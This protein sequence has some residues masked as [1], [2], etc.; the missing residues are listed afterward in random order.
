M[1]TAPSILALF[2]IVAGSSA[3]PNDKRQL[4]TTRVR[5][6]G[7]KAINKA[8]SKA[9]HR[10]M[11]EAD[12]GDMDWGSADWGNMDLS[13]IDV[14]AMMAGLVPLMCGMLEADI[15]QEE[16]QTQAA[17]EGVVCSRF[18]CDYSN[19]PTVPN[20]V[21]DCTMDDEF[22]DDEDQ[23]GEQFCITN[24]EIQ[25][26]LGLDF[27]NESEMEVTQCSDYTKPE[28]MKAMGRGC[29]DFGATLNYG[30]LVEAALSGEDTVIG[31][32]HVKLTQCSAEFS[33]GTGC[34][35]GT[36]N[37]GTGFEFEC[38]NE[39]G[40]QE[41]TDFDTSI[42]DV[43]MMSEGEAEMPAISVIRLSATSQSGTVAKESDAINEDT[44]VEK[45]SGSSPAAVRAENL[46]AGVILA[47]A[48][49]LALV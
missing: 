47:S 41:C 9:I 5:S 46:A 24:S 3:N 27:V 12:D 14:A 22:C 31:E 17:A 6:L 11:N 37:E 48:F 33:D 1:H 2:G 30:A 4:P 10:R 29:L 23:D 15:F 34:S 13:G 38:D 35:C 16:I 7:L 28:Y 36:C 43:G 49:S 45:D 32:E 21:M 26:S 20:L 8:R 18:G 25:M 40:S 39:L 44:G 19:N 42:P